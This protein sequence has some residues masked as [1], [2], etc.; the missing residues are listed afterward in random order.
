MVPLPIRLTGRRR[1]SG[2]ERLENKNLTK[3]FFRAMKKIIVFLY[4]AMVEFTTFFNLL[5][6]VL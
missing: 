6:A 5:V 2:A 1:P 4:Q 3:I